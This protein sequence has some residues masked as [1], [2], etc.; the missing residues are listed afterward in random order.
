MKAYAIVIDNNAVSQHGYDQ[1]V[2]SSES[3]GNDFKI[4][5]MSGCYACL[6]LTTAAVGIGLCEVIYAVYLIIRFVP[7]YLCMCLTIQH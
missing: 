3:A 5:K 7:Q 1:L 6:A 2:K 4:D